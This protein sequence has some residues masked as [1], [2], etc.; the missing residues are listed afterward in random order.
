MYSKVTMLNKKNQV[1][2]IEKLK[3]TKGKEVS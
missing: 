1:D 3:K 2:M